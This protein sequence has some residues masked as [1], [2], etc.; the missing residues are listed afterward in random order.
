[1]ENSIDVKIY[2]E[3]T[4]SLGV[5]YYANYLKYFERGRTE[6]I[7]QAGANVQDWNELGYVLVVHKITVTFHKPAKLG[8]VV[9][10]VTRAIPKGGD[11]RLHMEQ[12]VWRD[13]ERLTE[14]KVHLACLDTDLEL[15]EFPPGL[16]RL[17]EPMRPQR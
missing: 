8:D 10:V 17:R 11:F 12:E 1:M 9:Q 3:D 14:A 4:D 7:L 16:L 15:Q 13:G 2:Y 6:L 5:V